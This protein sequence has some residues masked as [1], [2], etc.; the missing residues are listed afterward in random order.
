MLELH[1]TKIDIAKKTMKLSSSFSVETTFLGSLNAK[2][3]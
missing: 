2:S 1:G 3:N